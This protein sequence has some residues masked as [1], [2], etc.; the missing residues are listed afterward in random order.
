[1]SD[2]GARRADGK[3]L[4]WSALAV[5]DDRTEA[6][7]GDRDD[8]RRRWKAW[9]CWGNIIQFLD[10]T[11]SGRADGLALARTTLDTFDAALLAAASGPVGGLL[12][13]L[14]DDLPGTGLHLPDDRAEE[15]SG[16]PARTAAPAPVAAPEPDRSEERRVGTEW[17]TRGARAL[18]T[19]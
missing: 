7:E 13:A 19:N 1:P 4:S 2:L 10:P 11:G 18:D 16:A 12:S 14:R 6:V 3:G 15:E 9:L 8:H 17:R 5:L